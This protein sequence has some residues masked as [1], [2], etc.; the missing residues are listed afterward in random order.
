MKKEIKQEQNNSLV[1]AAFIGWQMGAG[2]KNSFKNYLRELGLWERI[3]SKVK[4]SKEELRRVAERGKKIGEK[5][6]KFDKKYK[7]NKT[8]YKK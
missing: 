6:R 8:Q 1:E 5:I 2:G 3:Q 7:G 4:T